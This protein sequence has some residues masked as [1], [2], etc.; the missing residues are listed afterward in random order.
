MVII[1]IIKIEPL[2]IFRSSLIGYPLFL[3]LMR[4]GDLINLIFY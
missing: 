2:V 1:L 4:E 3:L